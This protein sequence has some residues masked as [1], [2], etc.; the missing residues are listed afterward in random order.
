MG[1]G[2]LCSLPRL[3]MAEPGREPRCLSADRYRSR[4]APP[5]GC[6]LV[7]PCV[8]EEA[9]SLALAMALPVHPRGLCLAYL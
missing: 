6:A 3:D 2:G 8:Q 9:M 1:T 7:P 5:A 4:V